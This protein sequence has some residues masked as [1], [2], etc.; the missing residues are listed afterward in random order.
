MPER[1]LRQGDSLSAF[2]LTSALVSDIS[3][4][5]AGVDPGIF[6]R[7]V[8]TSPQKTIQKYFWANHSSVQ[9]FSMKKTSAPVQE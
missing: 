4:H 2:I 3:F 9:W 8:Q 5:V 6:Y 1:G 7:V